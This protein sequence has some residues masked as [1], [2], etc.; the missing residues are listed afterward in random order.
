VKVHAAPGGN[1]SISL[2]A[3]IDTSQAADVD[4]SDAAAISFLAEANQKYKTAGKLAVRDFHMVG[5]YPLFEPVYT[6]QRISSMSYAEKVNASGRLLN[7]LNT[8]T[9]G[10]ATAAPARTTGALSESTNAVTQQMADCTPFDNQQQGMPSRT[11]CTSNGS[12]T[13]ANSIGEIPSVKV[14]HAPGG[15]SSIQLW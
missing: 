2:G 11:V 12:D 1:S 4:K 3:D 9:G 8:L 13:C 14:H 7:A 5:S 10:A 6:E 15:A